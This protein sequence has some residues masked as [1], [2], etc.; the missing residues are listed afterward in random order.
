MNHSL[1]RFMEVSD[2]VGKYQELNTEESAI[3][4]EN[5][6]NSMLHCF[7]VDG[8]CLVWEKLSQG[9]DNKAH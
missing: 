9:F 7:S 5:Q 1:L 4:L 6:G 2:L 3:I 8:V